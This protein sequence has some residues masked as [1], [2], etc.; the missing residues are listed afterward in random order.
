MNTHLDDTVTLT[1]DGRKLRARP[2]TYVLQ[3]A[4][5]AG[6]PIPTLC[7]HPDLEPSGACR[8]C[9]VEVTHPDWG[10]WRGLMT[11]C[12]YPV[13]EGTEVPTN[14][15]AVRDA[16]RRVLELL[17]A[18]S[19]N[20]P[21]IQ[22]LAREY[23]ADTRWL[24]VDPEGNDCILCGLCTRAC[25][26]YATTAIGTSRRG[27]DKQVGP[28]NDQPPDTCVGCGACAMVCPTGFIEA[29]R[30]AT[31][32]RIWDR[33]F[34]TAICVVDTDRCIGCGSCEEACPF[35]VARVG[36][37]ADGKVLA[38]I[39][40]EHCRGCGACVAPC[41]TGAIHQE[42]LAWDDLAPR[43]KPATSASDTGAA[44]S[45][46]V[47]ACQRSTRAKPG[48]FDDKTV[49]EVP[50]VGRVSV[51][52]ILSGLAQGLPG[53]LVL[54]RHQ[55]TCRMDGAEDPAVAVVHQA[56]E[57]AG[58]LGIDP[59]RIRFE[60][61]AP[62]RDGPIRT[63]QAFAGALEPLPSPA[64]PPPIP[65]SEGLDGTLEIVRP[66]YDAPDGTV[67]LSAWCAREGIPVAQAG[68][69]RLNIDWIPVW[70]AL[71]RTTTRPTRLT[72]MVRAALEVLP[73]LGQPVGG[74]D[75]LLA[76]QG[77]RATARADGACYTLCPEERRRL[78]ASGLPA[79]LVDDII[80]EH[81]T[82][83]PRPATRERVA[84]DGTDVRQVAL[85]EALG[86]EPVD[87]GPDP[88][89]DRF[90]LSP[91]H[92]AQADARLARAGAAEAPVLLVTTPRALLR[93]GMLT[94]HGTWRTN[95]VVPVTGV[96]LAALALSGTTPTEW[97]LD[98]VT[99]AETPSTEGMR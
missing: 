21:L 67:D 17:V 45:P 46:G 85:I 83:L 47:I 11:S 90:T 16:R 57:V 20:A 13:A 42:G 65:A 73:A 56:R 18:R 31:D 93:W 72:D 26:A 6:I 68:A 53:V 86:L 5:D 52:L 51:P 75:W 29:E 89:P 95:R 28:F 79:F 96:Q 23:H 99:P 98:R 33:A 54:G 43:F 74:A 91:D 92:R 59:E 24:R 88:L 22:Q 64:Q 55:A 8:L 30:T 9:V 62:G 50:C 37:S 32:Y 81:G 76:N 71:T 87:V 60:D 40:P 48:A 19:P 49:L 38:G 34:P 35:H 58:M 70:D 69:S 3:V 15:Q 97:A 12:L 82:T 61:P 25:E 39:A 94:R 63:V 10:G 4:R 80:R 44:V 66:L 14:S 77:H 1:V 78:E 41:P 36:W 27:A 2:G 84:C 7:D